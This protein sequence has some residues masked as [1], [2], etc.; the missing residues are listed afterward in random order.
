MNPTKALYPL[1]AVIALAL[2]AVA[3]VEGAGLKYLFGIVLP[4]AAIVIFAGGV[5]YRFI[6]W[7][8]SPV[9]FR[10]PTTCG[11][12]KSLPW[13]K[14]AKL[15]NPSTAVG[16]VGRML[17]EVFL[18]RSL[19]RNTKTYLTSDGDLIHGSDKRLWAA[20]MVFH[21]AFLLILIR[22]LRLFTDPVP[23]FVK[24]VE[25]YDGFFQIGTPVVFITALLF[26][27]AVAYLLGRRFFNPLVR[28]LSN[29]SDYFP[30]YAILGIAITGYWMRYVDK[31]DIVL[32]KKLTVGLFS[33]HPVV[34]EGVGVI[35][36]VHLMM[37]CALAIYAPFSKMV[38]MGGILFSPTRNMAN[39]NRMR[40]HVNP[41]DY[42]VKV[43]TYEQYED[44][45]RD[46]MKQVGVPVEK[47]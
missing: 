46:K 14:Q 44:E 23:R 17:L 10:I 29:P 40:R 15:E 7:A 27:I 11:Q 38:L 13:I 1:A 43:H 24:T 19:F 9:P 32:V 5:V 12:Q 25:F 26:I 37:V 33:L 18:F 41:W 2:I 47:E 34:P 3:G 6:Y 31:V 22:H 20:S 4:Y 21:W 30:L 16:V 8:R 42:P 45:F 28:Y 36:Y 35:F 39:N